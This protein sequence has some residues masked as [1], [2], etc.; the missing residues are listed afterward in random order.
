MNRVGLYLSII[1][2]WMIIL[3]VSLYVFIRKSKTYD[4]LYF[5]AVSS[6]IISWDLLGECVLSYLEK[7]SLDETYVLKSDPYHSPFLKSI[8]PSKF[9]GLL[10]TCGLLLY[11]YNIFVMMSIYKVPIPII[12][13][14][15]IS[16]VLHMIPSI[17]IALSSSN[18]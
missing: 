10:K 2:H 6:I 18:V 11:L 9:I 8:F 7:K 15:S 4:L 14:F 5:F 12:L 13:T 17:Q 1:I 16:I 3:F